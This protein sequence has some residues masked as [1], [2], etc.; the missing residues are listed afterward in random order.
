[1]HNYSCVCRSGFT[2]PFCAVSTTVTFNGT[3]W[4][5]HNK[6]VSLSQFALDFAFR[7]TLFNVTLFHMADVGHINRIFLILAE[8][9]LLTLYVKLGDSS[10][11]SLSGYSER[12]LNDA[13]WHTVMI[14]TKDGNFRL[15][16]NYH[17]PQVLTLSSELA[18]STILFGGLQSVAQEP[19]LTAKPF[20]G[21]LQD[22][23]I[24]NEFVLLEDYL[25]NVEMASGVSLGCPRKEPCALM[26]CQHAGTCIDLWNKFTCRCVRPFIGYTCNACKSLLFTYGCGVS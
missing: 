6:N 25:S 5:R 21:C 14:D 16:L 13:Q 15:T 4:M 12:D 24:N 10:T 26:P 17:D 7:T 9:Q 11:Q 1:M 8:P 22:I 23:R 19:T 18:F 20:T 3:A 2:G